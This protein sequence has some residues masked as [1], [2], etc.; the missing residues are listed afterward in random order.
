MKNLDEAGSVGQ[1]VHEN[2]AFRKSK[3]K[4]L[5][6]SLIGNTYDLINRLTTAWNRSGL[7]MTTN[8]E[9]IVPNNILTAR[10]TQYM[11]GHNNNISSISLTSTN[12]HRSATETDIANIALH[13]TDLN[14]PNG[15]FDEQASETDTGFGTVAVVN[16]QESKIQATSGKDKFVKG[17]EIN[18]TNKHGVGDRKNGVGDRKITDPTKATSG[19]DKLVEGQ[20]INKTNKHGVGD[21]T[22]TRHDNGKWN[23]CTKTNHTRNWYL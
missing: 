17:Q 14:V 13:S 8:D 7:F 4:S 18:K 23:Y 6:N 19:K 5:T 15:P 9:V 21:S 10:S 3:E 12:S 11:P 2:I 1:E 16:E 20:E 22:F